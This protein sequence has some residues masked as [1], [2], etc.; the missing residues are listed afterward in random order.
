MKTRIY[1]ILL[2]AFVS[3]PLFSQNLFL[4]RDFWATKPSVEIIKQNMKQQNNRLLEMGPGNWDGPMMAIQA[5]CDLASIKFIFNQPGIDVNVLLHHSNNYLMWTAAK[6]NLPVMEFLVEKGSK[7][8]LINSHGQSLL[9]H[10]P[11]SGKADSALYEFCIRNGAD[12][13]NDKDSEGR[14]VML[15]AIGYLKD[16]SFLDYFKS[17]GL[18]LNDTDKKGNGLF[19][20]AVAGANLKNIKELVAM[21]VSILPNEASENAF[22]FVGRGRGAKMNLELLHYLKSLGL[23]PSTPFAN[24][25]NLAH[26]ASR[27]G[28]DSLVLQFLTDNKVSFSQADKE[29]VTPL[30]LAATNADAHSLDFWISK[31]EMNA[32]TKLNQ[33]ALTFAVANNSVEVVKLLIDKGAAINIKDKEGNGLYYSLVSSYR[34]DKKNSVARAESIFN[35]LKTSGLE[36]PKTGQLLHAAFDKNDKELLRLLVKMGENM[37]AKD[38]DDYTI[39]HY[40]AMKSK[41]LELLKFLVENGAN[42]HIKTNLGESLIDLIRE[43]E[44]LN[45]QNLNLDFLK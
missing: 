16:L 37:N 34:K 1:F 10:V 23:D 38:K 22:S 43:N 28:A 35:L 18:S 15:V 19:H 39:L 29:G 31:N 6:G 11:M 9:M 20:Y 7:T 32:V 21:G 5:D 14:N 4:N 36:M 27:L 24:G 45:P 30:M 33:S 8:N 12:I 40:A 2:L 3:L 26:T 41:D 13:K 44:I 42:P 25:Q 17:K